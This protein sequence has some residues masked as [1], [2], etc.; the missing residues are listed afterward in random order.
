[1]GTEGEVGFSMT[2]TGKMEERTETGNGHS[3]QKVNLGQK[4]RNRNSRQE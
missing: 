2:E 3:T 4:H 1:M